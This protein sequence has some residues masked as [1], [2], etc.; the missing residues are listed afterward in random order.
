MAANSGAGGIPAWVWLVVGA[1]VIAAY[2]A[3]R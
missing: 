1:A 2:F 3:L